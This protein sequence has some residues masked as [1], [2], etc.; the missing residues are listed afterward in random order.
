MYKI[1]FKNT[2]LFLF[3]KYILFFTIIAFLD[4]RFEKI[5]L[6]KSDSTLEM[7][8]LTLGYV[9]YII[10]FL[11]PLIVFLCLPYYYVLKLKNSTLFATFII[12]LLIIESHIYTY[13]YSPSDRTLGIYSIFISLSFLIFFFFQEIKVKFKYQT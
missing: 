8:K 11:I 12:I 4:S 6:N 9:V 2:L 10:I 3:L 13:F 7:L 1:S 5:V